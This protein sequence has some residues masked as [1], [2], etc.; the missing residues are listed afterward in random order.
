MLDRSINSYLGLY[1]SNSVQISKKINYNFFQ[2]KI[3]LNY[4]VIKPINLKIIINDG[5]TDHSFNL[6]LSP[7][8]KMATVLIEGDINGKRID[9]V[10]SSDTLINK[11]DLKIGLVT[12]TAN[13][14]DRISRHRQIYMRPETF[15]QILTDFAGKNVTIIRTEKKKD[16]SGRE[17]LIE[18]PPELISAYFYQ[19]EQDFKYDE[20][21]QIESAKAVLLAKTFDNVTR[22]D[23]VVSDDIKFIVRTIVRV[24]GIYNHDGTVDYAFTYCEVS[25]YEN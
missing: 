22:D 13:A 16:A 9:F 6:L 24:P 17:R 23:I 15:Q 20:A 3:E 8:E 18:N 12:K 1:G 7:S 21:G 10:F 5:S 14:K 4:E 25:L 19:R 2:S 11:G